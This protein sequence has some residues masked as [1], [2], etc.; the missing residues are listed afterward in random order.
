MNSSLKTKICG[1]TRYEDLLMADK[2]GAD[3]FGFILCERSPRCIG[4]SNLSAMIADLPLE[5]CIFVDVMPSEEQLCTYQALGCKRFQIHTEEGVDSTIYERLSRIVSRDSL[6]LAPQI[7]KLE[8]FDQALLNK[9]D[10]F[11]ID[12]Y[13]DSQIGGTGK[14]GD[15]TGFKNL[16]E[17]H[18]ENTWILAGGLHPGNVLEAVAHSHADCIDINSGVETSPGIKDANALTA[19]FEALKTI[20]T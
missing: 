20:R 4:L 13:S 10:T 9:F 2:L 12:T 1:L 8:R 18:V 16:K 5:R 11:L 17:R 3:Y 6:W 19:L 7:P 14:V 15:W